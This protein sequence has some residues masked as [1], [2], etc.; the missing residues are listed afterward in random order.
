M[1][2][3]NLLY[4]LVNG[5]ISVGDLQTL[6]VND[7]NYRTAL[8]QIFLNPVKCETLVNSS[9]AMERVFSTEKGGELFVNYEYPAFYFIQNNSSTNFKHLLKNSYCVEYLLGN[10]NAYYAITR[11]STI[12]NDLKSDFNANPS[13]YKIK[14]QVFTSNGTWTRPATLKYVATVC[15]GAGGGRGASALINQTGGSGGEVKVVK[16]IT[17][18]PVSN[19]TIE[20]G[21][22]TPTTDD[23]TVQSSRFVGICTALGGRNGLT[24]A[25]GDISATR[26]TGGGSTYGGGR[27]SC[28]DVDLVNA[29][30]MTRNWAQQGGSSGAVANFPTDK[31]GTQ[32][33]SGAGGILSGAVFTA[34]TGYGSGG[35][36][37]NQPHY[38]YIPTDPNP[39]L[40]YSSPAANS[41]CGAN[42]YSTNVEGANG[43]VVVWWVE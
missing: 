27:A 42:A 15:V 18:L 36:A 19:V 24:T 35:A 6:L 23:T 28:D 9:T 31:D 38:G 12:Y 33:L 8:Q 43:L 29:V 26:R 14:R 17:G 4:N 2:A 34:P 10:S 22:S 11:N 30:V 32:G 3:D 40:P 39:P 13:L 16:L 25:S 5:L 7:A 21:L 1:F 20:V 41:G 37:W